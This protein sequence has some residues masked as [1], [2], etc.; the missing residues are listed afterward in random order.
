MYIL[1]GSPAVTIQAV[2]SGWEHGA[3]K[4]TESR[5]HHNKV[6]F[7][8]W[9]LYLRALLAPGEDPSG[10]TPITLINTNRAMVR[11][12]CLCGWE[13]M[14]G[15]MMSICSKCI[16]PFPRRRAPIANRSKLMTFVTRKQTVGGVREFARC[17][18]RRE[19]GPVPTCI[20][21]PWRVQQIENSAREKEK[22][23]PLWRELLSRHEQV[24]LHFF[25]VSQARLNV[26]RRHFDQG[27][28]RFRKGELP[29]DCDYLML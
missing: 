21:L 16:R 9:I 3:L 22:L 2:K 27:L 24:S 11:E 6:R 7:T 14:V 1:G 5:S 18:Y 10:P 15:G 28:R 20:Y 19:I 13:L 17:R 29:P 12:L 25:L 23:H 4:L 8:G 26:S